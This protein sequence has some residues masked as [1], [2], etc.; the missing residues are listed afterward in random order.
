MS[1]AYVNVEI[2]IWDAM[3]GVDD[4]VLIEELEDRGYIVSKQ[5]TEELETLDRYD[6]DYLLNQIKFLD[7]QG[8]DVYEKLRKLRF[9]Q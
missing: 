8:R 2:D 5:P 9:G 3:G 7:L 1:K 6:L 4:D